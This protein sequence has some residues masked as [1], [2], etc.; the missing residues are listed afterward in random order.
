MCSGV[1]AFWCRW[2]TKERVKINFRRETKKKKTKDLHSKEIP[3]ISKYSE[4]SNEFLNHDFDLFRLE[5]ATERRETENEIR[6]SARYLHNKIILL[7][8]VARFETISRPNI[9][10]AA[11]EPNR[12]VYK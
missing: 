6:D 10:H 11:Q 1:A 12:P 9:A 5:I 7:R 4:H 3:N 2:D 8:I